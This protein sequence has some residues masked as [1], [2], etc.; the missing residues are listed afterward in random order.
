MK[1]DLNLL[2][3]FNAIM[4]EQ[5]VTAAARRLGLSQ[6]AVSAALSRLRTVF[7]D[8]LFLRARYGVVPTEKAR[9]IAPEIAR[10][11]DQLNHVF[12]NKPDFDP[13][14]SARK[15]Q[16][17]ASTYFECA[18]IPTLMSRVARAAPGV[19][20][21]VEP[22]GPDPEVKALATGALDLALGRFDTAPDSL[23]ITLVLDD[24]FV[25]V[26]RRDDLPGQLTVTKAQYESL[27]H[28][29]V[30]PPGR[31]RTGLFQTLGTAGLKRHIAL[32]VSHFLAAP[33]AVSEIGGLTTLPIRIARLFEKDDR[34]KLLAPPADLGRFPMH[35]AW[36]PRHRSDPGHTWLRGLVR[37]VCSEL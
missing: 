32:T 7:D 11:L 31:W 29:V 8:E 17:A 36:H 33:L 14:T 1:Y 23:V 9:T 12:E 4:E 20:L 21:A 10:A 24:G 13:A 15:F 5:N 18:V 2:A 30:S 16:I 22:L 35:L 3:V 27:P 25:C 28:V 37:T 19:S 34:F 6:S 26:L